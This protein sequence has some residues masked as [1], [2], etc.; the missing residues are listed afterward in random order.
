[1]GELGGGQTGSEHGRRARWPAF[2][3]FLGVCLLSG[4]GQGLVPGQIKYMRR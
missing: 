1:M 2:G 3:G 4:A